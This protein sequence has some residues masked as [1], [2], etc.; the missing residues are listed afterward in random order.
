MEK[1][2]FKILTEDVEV[3]Q[4]INEAQKN[5]AD[6]IFNIIIENEQASTI[7]LQGPWGS[8]KSTIIKQ[9]Q[10]KL[11][12]PNKYIYF[13]FDA[14]AH[15]GDFLRKIFLRNLVE[16]ISNKSSGN[17][18]KLSQIK[19]ELEGFTSISLFGIIL[20]FTILFVPFGAEIL[21][22]ANL[23]ELDLSINLSIL[24]S[25][26][27]LI[28]GLIKSNKWIN[29]FS[30][31]L[32]SSAL[33][34]LPLEYIISSKIN[35]QFI[36]GSI[37]T[38]L[39]AIVIIVKKLNPK[40]SL[41]KYINL[42]KE[43]KLI[44]NVY[45]NDSND[46]S[47][48]DFEQYFKGILKLFSDKKFI[49]VIDNLDRIDHDDAK[50]IWSTLQIFLQHRNP[51]SN[52]EAAEFYKNLWIIIPYDHSSLIKIWGSQA[53]S[54]FI[55]S[56]LNNLQPTTD[57]ELRKESNLNIND[58]FLEKCFQIRI[59]IPNMTMNDWVNIA[60]NL[61]KQACPK[62]IKTDI[63]NIIYEMQIYVS[64]IT[65]N[66][67]PRTL[68]LYINQ[69]GF[70]YLSTYS[71]YKEKDFPFKSLSFFIIKKYLVNSKNEKILKSLI[72][73]EYE[74][75]K[76]KYSL[77]DQYVENIAC[78][79]YFMEP[80]KALELF[81]EKNINESLFESDHV[82]LQNLAIKFPSS[83]WF[84]F[85]RLNKQDV[86]FL[87]NL[88]TLH[89][90]FWNTTEFNKSKVHLEELI[91][92]VAEPETNFLVRLSKDKKYYKALDCIIEIYTN[93]NKLN[94]IATLISS[95]GNQNKDINIE[96]LSN[97]YN[98]DIQWIKTNYDYFL[99]KCTKIKFQEKKPNFELSNFVFTL[100]YLR[101]WDKKHIEFF[102]ISEG[103]HNILN[104]K[105]F[106]ELNLLPVFML[107]N[108]V[109]YC[110]FTKYPISN[111]FVTDILNNL[112]NSMS[113][114]SQ[115][116]NEYCIEVLISLFYTQKYNDIIKEHFTSFNLA[117]IISTLNI[118]EETK[119]KV[120]F[121]YGMLS[122]GIEIFQKEEKLEVREFWKKR[123]SIQADKIVQLIN[124]IENPS[125]IKSNLWVLAKF[126]YCLIIDL[127]LNKGMMNNYFDL[128]DFFEE[129]NGILTLKPFYD[130]EKNSIV[131]KFYKNSKN[132]ANKILEPENI[133]NYPNVYL[134]L[135]DIISQIEKVKI[136]EFIKTENY[137]ERIRTKLKL[138]KN[139]I[140]KSELIENQLKL[141]K[142]LN[143]SDITF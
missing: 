20:G 81:I 60:E 63:D 59:D 112:E 70:Y 124:K 77:E 76:V 128:D 121:L 57:Q 89:K 103:F 2:K 141:T 111:K 24:V 116:E 99:D 127:F 108:Y 51:V 62:M 47:S 11:D 65:D 6:G 136:I 38:L 4:S 23:S 115:Q 104:E 118:N 83:F 106:G 137:E 86:E 74:G 7:G 29:I 100:Q 43:F 26:I 13:Y 94:D 17:S 85:D 110:I 72:S 92:K 98:K 135:V 39:P 25:I 90:A 1:L 27:A 138:M 45:K 101:H 123:D 71:F 69:I 53:N 133:I 67:K 105:D 54:E 44:S 114:E 28:I 113:N 12:D 79:S 120:C 46:Q 87:T 126:N 40:L 73:S 80:E 31:I 75:D 129:L 15:E 14:W 36:F 95:I 50:K 93:D 84:L 117:P 30:L 42:F 37:F 32:I 125:Y 66:P 49:I 82:K 102:K 55:D 22:D 122:P 119:T 61:L 131:L 9:V 139:E 19:N 134:V 78:F 97:N 64:S 56:N 5:I 21:S 34:I 140:E 109:D 35:C 58:S 96:L 3:G 16:E 68:K 142:K 88:P 10:E 91:K 41:G 33:N 52:S 107:K 130:E 132:I 18:E 143:I 48:I 8:G